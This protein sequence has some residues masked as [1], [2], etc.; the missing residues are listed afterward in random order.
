MV[1]RSRFA[2]IASPGD[3]VRDDEIPRPDP[4]LQLLL[5][6]LE[7]CELGPQTEKNLFLGLDVIEECLRG[8]RHRVHPL[9]RPT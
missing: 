2:I 4:L 8:Q 7:R 1:S 6:R 9:R 3:K 5:E